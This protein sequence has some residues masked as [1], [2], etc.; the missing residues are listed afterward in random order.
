M[1]AYGPDVLL[2]TGYYDP[3]QVVLML[4]AKLSGIKV[5]IQTES[6]PVD[7]TRTVDRGNG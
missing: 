2:L 7:Q 3:A 6:T 1:R 5:I 4:V